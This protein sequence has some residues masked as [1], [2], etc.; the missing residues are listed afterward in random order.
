MI[1][2]DTSPANLA[3]LV[4][5][6]TIKRNERL[7]AV[8]EREKV[9]LGAHAPFMERGESPENLAMGLF[10]TM[11]GSM[12]SSAPAASFTS[13]GG[14]AQMVAAAALGAS[15]TDI[16]KASRMERALEPAA[17]DFWFKPFCAGFVEMGAASMTDLT[18]EERAAMRGR[19]AGRD[20]SGTVESSEDD[21]DAPRANAEHTP[22]TPPHWPRFKRLDPRKC[23]WDMAA[24]SFA[25]AR[26]TFHEVIESR[27]V[28]FGRAVEGD[29]GWNAAAISAAPKCSMTGNADDAIVG[30]RDEF[31]R[32]FVVYVRGATLEGKAPGP[33]QPGVIYTVAA[34]GMESARANT[35][36]KYLRDPYYFT[37]HP[38]GPH[39][40][41]GQYTTGHDAMF[42]NLLGAV[43]DA[44]AMLESVSAS[45]HQRI[46]DHKVVTAY[47]LRMEEEAQALIQAP[48]GDY[49]GIAGLAS[50]PNMIQ[51]VETSV[52]TPAE[53]A[54]YRELQVNANRQ[55]GIS[56][57]TRG[58]ADGDATAT[59]VAEAA[60]QVDAKV[61]Y[62]MQRWMRFVAES[63][64]RMAFYVA[65][66]DRVAVRVGDLGRA[67]VLR[68]YLS[69]LPG[70][71]L[72]NGMRLSQ[73]DVEAIVEL[74]RSK[75][76][77][78]EGGDFAESAEFDWYS[79]RLEVRP[80]SMTG[81]QSRSAVQRE[82]AWNEVSAFILQQMSMNPAYVRYWV[83]RLEATGK[84]MGVENAALALDVQM[85]EEMAQAMAM[86][87]A[88]MGAP[89]GNGS[90]MP[91]RDGAMPIGQTPQL[92]MQA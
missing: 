66:D 27:T 2:L 51:Q 89:A 39:V 85:A 41:G 73:R 35:L 72:P 16:A 34:Q 3:A 76:M 86:Q 54:E 26:F 69:G 57:S 70:T 5:Y 33:N 53:V 15:V 8:K 91:A 44:L 46:R 9:A 81:G 83:T 29:A 79:M 21:V 68:A 88:S 31:V 42:V 63:L 84:A 20:E 18:R 59:A 37:G 6:S 38:D 13:S 64:E 55:V 28:L 77:T 71:V 48:N 32:Y 90:A 7:D 49:V 36:E 19:L 45:M 80:S 50:S 58:L 12:V 74:E 25:E 52:V 43:E 1:G 60:S 11:V 14:R 17:W 67:E 65:M 92:Q 61:E 30:S 82:N 22:H 56:D 87:G 23:G 4:N 24:G 40:F 47:D 78:Y 62:L 75:P 10:S